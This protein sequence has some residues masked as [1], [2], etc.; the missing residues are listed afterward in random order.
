VTQPPLQKALL[1]LTGG[2]ALAGG[3]LTLGVAALVVVSV[4]GRWLAGMPIEGDFEFVRMATALA[5]FAFLPFTQARGAHIVVDSLTQRLPNPL[6]RAL[7]A[8]WNLLYGLVM[9]ALA[10]GLAVG[11]RDALLS[12][13][14]TMQLQLPVWPVIALCAGL[15]LLLAVTA[16]VTAWLRPD[17]AAE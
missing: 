6:I 7:D 14:T 4:T 16:V 8:L 13:E 1:R 15:C 2:V 3:C 10:I 17:R 11:A 12:R 5:V 9:G